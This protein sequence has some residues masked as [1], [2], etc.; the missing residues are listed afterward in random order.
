MSGMNLQKKAVF[1]VA[2]ILFF[3]IT[4]NTAV[5]TLIA[6]DKYRKAILSK[7]S[8]IGEGLQRDFSKV[9]GLGV[10]IESL[11]GI[12][13]KL[14]DVTAQDKAIGY[15]MVTD[16]A[17]KVLF[18]S[19]PSLAGKELKD[20]ASL[21]AAASA[22]PLVQTTASFYDLSFPLLNADGKVTGALRIGVQMKAIKAQ[23]YQLLFWALGVSLLCFLLS[24]LLVYFS[25]SKFITTP[26]MLMEKAADR[27]AS[28]ELSSEIQVK[29]RDEVASLGTAINRM[30]LN[31]KDMLSKISG[32]TNSVSTVTANISASSHSV[33]T[34][35]DVQKKAIEETA[36]SIEGMDASISRVAA[37]AG[38]LSQ[39]AGDASSSIFEMS[40]SIERVA[41][42]ANIFN[43]TAHET[44]SSIEEMVSTIKQIAE[45]I[46]NLSA[47]AEAIASSI[48]EVNATTRDIE[49]SANESVELAETVMNN[50][51]VKGM[52]AADIAM[53]G[54][55]NIRKSVT[56]LSEVINML[57]KRTDDI[58]K[59]LNVIDDVADQTNL[60]ALNAAILA[61]KA[62]EHGKGFSIV[63]DE[64][65]SLAERTSVSTNEIASLIQSVQDVTKSSIR[66]ASEGIHTVERGMTL[67]SDV[68]G[69][70]G[71]I[72]ESSKA[73]TEMAKAIQRATS[74]ESL[75]IKQ[76]TNAVE[77][78][79]TQTDNIS[80]AIQEQSRGS[81]LIIEASEKVKELSTQVKNSTQEQKDGSRQIA[82]VIENV[83]Q[84]AGQIAE[85]TGR[86]K[87]NSLEVIQSMEKI[88]NTTDRLIE[89][90]TEMSVVI[91]S[92]KDEALSLLLELRKFKV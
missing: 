34:V 23:L 71:E 53:E 50:A 76:I 86:Q 79:T 22:I 28:G 83:T 56:E 8:A 65:K 59:I 21:K 46:E 31:L 63:A 1:I 3:I 44:A 40:A 64:I 2:G 4:I 82:V 39:S 85:A 67:V 91:T 69:A 74:E 24:L 15:A 17:G 36:S 78:M 16:A 19:D 35:A 12:N 33:M 14:K 13:E 62:G 49:R 55:R 18:H 25:I 43:E 70:L 20:D 52:N 42:N 61:S 54:M 57:G 10:A 6:S 51:T 87:E 72:V 27:I 60:L 48:D 80:R 29:G 90:S 37:S 11:E 7:T 75:V 26:I 32:I 45:S 84:Q 73:S 89:S 88:R 81:R 92:L 30:V 66:L 41:E 47:S 9:L 68:N 58:G 77:T 5:L 38:I